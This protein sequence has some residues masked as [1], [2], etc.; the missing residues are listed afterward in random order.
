MNTPIRS[1]AATGSFFA[2]P[3]AARQALAMALRLIEPLMSDR[4]VVGSGFLHIVVM[5]PALGPEDCGFD[6]AVLLEHSIG[7]RARWDAD[8]ADFARAKAR[9]AWTQGIDTQ[10]VQ[11]LAPH[12]L[13]EG[14][15]LLWG[16][17]HLDGIVVGVSGAHAPYDEAFATCIAACLRAIA[18]QRWQAA[19]E[20]RKL[21]AG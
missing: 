3:E 16:S 21:F 20:Q 9:L 19:V 15:T 7:D 14:D 12:R 17:A 13:R 4:H 11:T 2:D 6:E 10:A 8:Y 18:K 5:D 1:T